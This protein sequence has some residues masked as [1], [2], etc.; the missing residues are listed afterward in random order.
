MKNTRFLELMNGVDN[1]LLERAAAPKKRTHRKKILFSALAACLA[2]CIA[3]GAIFGGTPAGTISKNGFN[4]AKAVYPLEEPDKAPYYEYYVQNGGIAEFY[5]NS[6]SEMLK[7]ENGENALYS[8][9]NVYMALA[10]L[11]EMTEGETR[12]QI[13]ALLGEE[14]M[15]ELRE[16]ASALWAL[17]YDRVAD[18]LVYLDI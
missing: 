13:L 12:A 17:S 15:E 16:T 3:L 8:P 10:M 5:K 7:T 1:D 4:I 6:I 18:K 14:S 11:A 9:A 2:L